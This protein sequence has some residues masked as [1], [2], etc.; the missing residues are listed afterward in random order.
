MCI[1]AILNGIQLVLKQYKSSVYGKN[2][3]H[4]LSYSENLLDFSEFIGLI[5]L[6]KSLIISN[7]TIPTIKICLLFMKSNIWK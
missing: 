6:K 7:S 2:K 3:D 4:E 1:A 5:F